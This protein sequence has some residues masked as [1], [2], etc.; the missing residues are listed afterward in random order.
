[1]K[2][3]ALS[4]LLPLL[5][6]AS[7][8]PYGADAGKDAKKVDKP[9]N[10]HKAHFNNFPFEFT[11]TA[12]A[13]ARPETIVNNS[14]VAVPGLEGGFGTF[15]FGL[16]S[17]QDV[18]CYVSG[19]ALIFADDKNITLYVKGTYQSPASTATHIHEAVKGRA[20]PPRLSFPNPVPLDRVSGLDS[21]SWRASFGC[22][23]GPFRTGLNGTDGGEYSVFQCWGAG[24]MICSRH[25][26]RVHDRCAGEECRGLLCRHAHCAIPRR[27]CPWPAPE[28]GLL[29][30]G[31]RV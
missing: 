14:Q 8:A 15:A 20:G 4:I 29:L 16:N 13:W 7:A 2:F 3:A 26:C 12:V 21:F 30:L 19:L 28:A 1:M 10:D 22:L 27:C 17:I 25:W 5:S 31:K 9:K 18:I 6:V 24:L 11:S 23:Q